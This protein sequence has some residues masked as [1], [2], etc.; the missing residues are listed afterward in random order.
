M[1][2]Y[3]LSGHRQKDNTM[4]TK[5][6]LVIDGIDLLLLAAI[7]ALAI[8]SIVLLLPMLPSLGRAVW[9]VCR[10]VLHFWKWPTWIWT[11]LGVSAL[12]FLLWLRQRQS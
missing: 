8:L 4:K 2:G 3:F 6:T 1:A 5:N 7:I 12:G 10:T 9:D 11:I